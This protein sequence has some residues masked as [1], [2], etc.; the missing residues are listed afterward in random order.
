MANFKGGKIRESGHEN[1][2]GF[3]IIKTCHASAMS[4]VDNVGAQ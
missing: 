3:I 1:L 4:I 2:S